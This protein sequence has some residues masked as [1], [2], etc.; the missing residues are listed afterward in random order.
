M[1]DIGIILLI[2]A[3]LE[4]LSGIYIFV[5]R[6][7][8]HIVYAHSIIVLGVVL[9]VA[10][11]GMFALNTT[12]DMLFFWTKFI[13]IGA[14]ILTVG[15][16]YFSYAFPYFDIQLRRGTTTLFIASLVYFTWL[17]GFTHLFIVSIQQNLRSGAYEVVYGDFYHVFALWFLFFFVWGFA[18]LWRKLKKA[19]GVHRWQ[20]RNVFI[21]VLLSFLVGATFNLILPWI[22]GP[23][24][25][26]I[27]AGSS[28]F[29]LAFTTYMVFN[30]KAR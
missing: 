19:S 27:G 12:N 30:K 26:Y 22:H 17:M 2:I 21:G 4:L 1:Q 15:F 13:Y 24:W 18:N 6:V 20:I 8:G 25:F 28:L 29:W 7:K 11:N 9:W 23:Q 5:T 14:V 3:A 16:V 10:G